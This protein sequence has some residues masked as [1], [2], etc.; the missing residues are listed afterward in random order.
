MR[1]N[2][3]VK[4]ETMMDFI[5]KN[6]MTND[7]PMEKQTK[8][9]QTNIHAFKYTDEYYE[10]VVNYNKNISNLNPLYSN[11]KPL[12]QILVRVLLHEPKKVGNLVMPFKQIFP[13]PTKSGTGN[14]AEIESDFPFKTEGIVVAVPDNNPLKPGDKVMLSRKAFQMAVVGTGANTR[15]DVDSFLH[16]SYDGQETPK[17][18]TNEHYGYILVDYYQIQAK[19]NGT[20]I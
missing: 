7:D 3:P 20:E 4:K 13:I 18:V 5:K 9:A 2:K 14:Y 6:H 10:Q 8:A 11:I 12:H 17:D 1:K 19:L 16:P 15:I